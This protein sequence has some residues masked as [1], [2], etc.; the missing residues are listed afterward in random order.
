MLTKSCARPP[1]LTSVL[2]SVRPRPPWKDERLI[3]VA[4]DKG[5]DGRAEIYENGIRGRDGLD[6]ASRRNRAA[7]QRVAPQHAVQLGSQ[8]SEEAMPT[9]AIDTVKLPVASAQNRRKCFP[10]GSSLP[11]VVS[12]F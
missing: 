8:A 7:G 10:M 9:F 11:R 5:A 1:V 4:T 12:P 6:A 2:P 3:V